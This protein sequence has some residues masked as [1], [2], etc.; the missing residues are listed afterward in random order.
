MDQIQHYTAAMHNISLN[1]ITIILIDCAHI[2]P[3]PGHIKA[4][5][6]SQFPLKKALC[7][8]GALLSL[9]LSANIV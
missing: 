6:F 3:I 7:I 2:L 1:L 5:A 4:V 9:K 8:G